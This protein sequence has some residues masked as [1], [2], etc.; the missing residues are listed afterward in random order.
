MVGCLGYFLFKTCHSSA[1]EKATLS[2]NIKT[3]SD[4]QVWYTLLLYNQALTRFKLL[5]MFIQ[6]KKVLHKFITSIFQMFLG[7]MAI[8]QLPVDCKFLLHY[9]EISC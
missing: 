9:Y 7:T 3:G 5:K 4:Y 8:W 2:N 6:Y 1:W